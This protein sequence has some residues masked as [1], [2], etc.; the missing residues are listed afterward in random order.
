MTD[1]LLCV[2]A[3]IMDDQG[4]IFV[5]R[6][7]PDR[8][9]FPDCWD[10]VG[11]HVEA[12]ETPR[13]ALA[14]EIAEETGWRLSRIL[15]VVG[16]YYWIGNDGIA[17]DEIDYLVEVDGDL[18]APRLEPGK[19]VDFRW[20]TQSGASLLLSHKPTREILTYQIVESGF[21]AAR[22]H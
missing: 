15:C 22:R 20:L 19:Q 16:V 11:G 9:L 1:T 17:R 14:R 12:G 7:S 4:R 13:E 2:G 21:M 5:H 8:R 10:I 3:L 18:A 6:R